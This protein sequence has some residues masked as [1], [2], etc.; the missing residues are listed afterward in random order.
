LCEFI[1]GDPWGRLVKLLIAPCGVTPSDGTGECKHCT[2]CALRTNSQKIKKP[3]FRSYDE[4]REILGV[5]FE[6]YEDYKR[7]MI[8]LHM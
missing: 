1:W 8:S 2:E 6:M 3:S 7:E 4:L 5:A